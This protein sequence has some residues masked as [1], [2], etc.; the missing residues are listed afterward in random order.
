MML[1]AYLWNGQDQDFGDIDIESF[2]VSHDAAAPQFY[3][4]MKDGRALSCWRI[5]AMWAIA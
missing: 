5:R 2:G 3:R 4:L 1:K